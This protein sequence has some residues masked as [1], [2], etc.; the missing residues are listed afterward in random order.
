MALDRPQICASEEWCVFIGHDY[1]NVELTP[2][3]LFIRFSVFE[4]STIESH[5]L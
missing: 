1:I 3:F 2:A 4:R 5:E